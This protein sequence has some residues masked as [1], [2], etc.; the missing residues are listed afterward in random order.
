MREEV[1]ELNY[2]TYR[3]GLI[4]VD[5]NIKNKSFYGKINIPIV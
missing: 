3:Y 4:S 5:S 1:S 2:Y